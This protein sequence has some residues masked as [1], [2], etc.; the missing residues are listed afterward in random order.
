MDV[1]VCAEP[2][3]LLHERRDR[4]ARAPG[5]VL[6]RVRRVGICGTDMHILAGKQPF[7]AYPRVMGHEMSGVVEEADADSG[8]SPGDP[9]CVMPYQSC[10]HCVAC[11]K[12]RPN[13]CVNIRVLGVHC[14][15]ALAEY[16]SV[17]SQFVLPL[18]GLD[19]DSAAM[20]EFLSIGAHAV[21]RA[22]IQA[23]DR[24]LVV[25]AGPIG[26]AAAIFAQDAGGSV[27][28]LDGRD[29][30][31]AFCRDQLGVPHT[32]SLGEDADARLAEITGGEMFDVIFDATGNRAAMEAGFLRLAHAGTYVLISVITQDITFPDPEFHK[33]ETTLLA[34]RNATI[35]DFQQV[36][37]AMKAGRIPLKA[38]AT[39]RAALLDLPD[40]LARWSLPDAG[41]IKAIVE[42]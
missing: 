25:G 14:D 1:V 7:L 42:V 18:D 31:L 29:D 15:G 38:L 33:R 27:T 20:V 11:R 41:V 39:H 8:F 13:C 3:V 23:G 5:E 4:P 37:A 24:V 26:I 28:A 21:R 2:G 34:S 17:K 35:E 10:G 19:L 40:L 22:R 36:I 16:V 9:V 6:I 30:R 12:G 32:V